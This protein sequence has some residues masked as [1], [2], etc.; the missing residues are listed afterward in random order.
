MPADTV[1]TLSLNEAHKNISNVTRP[2][3]P[4]GNI[5]IHKDNVSEPRDIVQALETEMTDDEKIDLA[6]AHI[7]E[8]FKPA[9]REL[10][11]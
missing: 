1:P 10:A 9:F 4:N 7:L 3:D 11:K 5:P 8:R 2:S 6:A